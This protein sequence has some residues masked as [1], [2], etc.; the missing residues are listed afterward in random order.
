MHACMQLII[1]LIEV[2]VSFVSKVLDIVKSKLL[3]LVSTTGYNYIVFGNTLNKIFSLQTIIGIV[4]YTMKI[5]YNYYMPCHVH[6]YTNVK[7]CCQL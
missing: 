5:Q 7:S 2:N 4:L 1:P 6:I 3:L